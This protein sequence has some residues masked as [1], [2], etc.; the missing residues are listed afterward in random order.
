MTA[1]DQS[2]VAPAVLGQVDGDDLRILLGLFPDHGEEVVGGA[3][4]DCDDLISKIRP[5]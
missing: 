1:A 2:V 5:L 3:V 4:V